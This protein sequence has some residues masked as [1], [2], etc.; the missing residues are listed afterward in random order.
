MAQQNYLVVEI[1][2][3]SDGRIAA[4]VN[5]FETEADAKSKFHDVMKSAYRSAYPVHSCIV[6]SAEAF[7]IVN[8][9]VKH[10]PQPEPEPEPEPE[11]SG[12]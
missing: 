4:P 9:C 12:E 10:T 1:I 2:T 8:E 5:A 11:P 6:L 3:Q 7:G